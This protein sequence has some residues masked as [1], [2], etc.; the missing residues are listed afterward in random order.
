MDNNRFAELSDKLLPSL[1]MKLDAIRNYLHDSKASLMVGAGFSKNADMDEST[2]MK[3]WF[4]LADDFYETLYGK[5][6]EDKDVKYRSVLRLASQVESSKGRNV[7]ESQIQ[8]SLPDD[9]VYPGKLHVKLMKMPWTDVFTTNYDS[10]LEKAFVEA[11][12]YYHKVTNKE[13]LLYA[14]HPRIVKLHGSFPDIRPFIITEEDFRTYPQRFPEMVNTVRQSLIENVMCLIGFSGDD[15]NFQSWLGW[16]RDI[17]G[18]QVAPVYQITYNKSMHESN[19]KLSYDLG[20]DV[21]NLAEIPDIN[22]FTEAL[23]FCLEYIG[24]PFETKWVPEISFLHKFNGLLNDRT[25]KEEDIKKDVKALIYKMQKVRTTYPGWYVLPSRYFKDFNDVKVEYPFAIRLVDVIADETT[26]LVD[27]LY[28]VCWRYS[29]TLSSLDFEWYVNR[30]TALPMSICDGVNVETLK[31]IITIKLSLLTIYRHQND[32]ESFTDLIAKLKSLSTYLTYEH[33]RTL[34]YELGLYYL[35]RFDYTHIETLLQDWKPRSFDYKG[36]IWK[37]SILSEAGRDKEALSLLRDT[38]KDIKKNILGAKHSEMLLSTKK[39][40]EQVLWYIDYNQEERPKYDENY[41]PIDLFRLFKDTISRSAGIK[42]KK[43]TT[44]S[45]SLFSTGTQYNSGENGFVGNFLGAYRYIRLYEELGMPV[46]ISFQPRIS[47]ELINVVKTLLKYHSEFS[48]LLLARGTSR[49]VLDKQID[50]SCLSNINREQISHVFSILYPYALEVL[51]NEPARHQSYRVL[52]TVMPLLSYMSVLLPSEYVKQIFVL[53][54][55]LYKRYPQFYDSKYV[56]QLYSCMNDA[57]II[58]CQKLAFDLPII[59]TRRGVD[60]F[61]SGRNLSEQQVNNDALIEVIKKLDDPNH[62][63]VEAAYERA[64]YLLKCKMDDTSLLPLKMAIIQWRNPNFDTFEKKH[65][66][67][68]VPVL[69]VGEK[70]KESEIIAALL[71]TFTAENFT[72][73]GSSVTISSF[74]KYLHKLSFFTD[75]FTEKQ[76]LK[77]VQKIMDVLTDNEELFKKDDSNSLMGGMRH[78]VYPIFKY[79]DHYLTFSV[80]PAADNVIWDKYS[81][82]LLRYHTYG[83]ASLSPYTRLQFLRGK[84]NTPLKNMIGQYVMSNNGILA[85]DACNAFVVYSEKKGKNTNQTIVKDMIHYIR[86]NEDDFAGGFYLNAVIRVLENGGICKEAKA[87]LLSWI[88]GLIIRFENQEQWSASQ[89]DILYHANV[90]AG[91]ISVKWPEWDKLDAW[92]QFM[93]NDRVF[94]DIRTGFEVGRNIVS[95]G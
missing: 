2:T 59:E 10:L 42:E 78:F 35:G 14:P 56:E 23:D 50:R 54:T 19:V 70:Y 93:D 74:T 11:D 77:Y 13:T 57:D 5:R 82:I 72:V 58:E 52:T 21:V 62:Q 45:F 22:D 41:N 34:A 90:L 63:I 27:F 48:F 9:R 32:N 7:L 51:E 81:E 64:V 46:S 94:N 75:R 88:E 55:K 40:I 83:F 47:D 49:E 67:S 25:R 71:Q 15:P 24:K 3:D 92:K 68:T 4:G 43:T 84:A 73:S 95:K 26:L 1:R 85:H 61:L 20:I 65:S 80:L 69:P 17:M 29:I 76:H 38:L 66:I 31:K 37:A 86:Y 16:L 89:C 44:H 87:L 6:P 79:L 36:Y 53:W 12:R 28:E 33:E 60:F 18:K 8:N 30:A 91:A 39:A